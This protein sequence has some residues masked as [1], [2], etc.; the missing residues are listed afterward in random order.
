[1]DRTAYEFGPPVLENF[2]VQYMLQPL[3]GIHLNSDIDGEFQANGSKTFLQVFMAVALLILLIA[4]FNF[5][6]LST[7]R[8]SWRAKEV[9]VKKVL[10]IE[11]SH[12]VA[13]F[14]GESLLLTVISAVLAISIVALVLPYF[15]AFSG[16]LLTNSMFF[17]WDLAVV[18]L[19]ILILV[20]LS[21]G[22]FPAFFLSSFQPLKVLKG[23]TNMGDTKLASRLRKGLVV[24]QFAI[25]MGLV[26]SSIVIYNQLSYA[27]NMNLG[28]KKEQV[29]VVDFYNRDLRK[30]VPLYKTAVQSLN[31]V[32]GVAA[33]SDTPPREL[34]S[35][36]MEYKKGEQLRKELVPVIAVVHN[37]IDV[38]QIGIK[39]GRNFS[40]D[41]TTDEQSGILVNEA[42]VKFFD[43]QGPLNAE[44]V[45]SEDQPVRILGVMED[46]HFN[47]VHQRIKPVMLRIRP[48]WH[49]HLM[50][51]VSDG[52]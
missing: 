15:S 4:C 8:A 6:N 28:L 29:I 9:G 1:V 41:F 16:K 17:S 7:A 14:L 47:S 36:W 33:T 32:S 30:Q 23:N 49:D 38:L 12:L 35:W 2:K 27:K 52:D 13:Q 39:E 22:S 43:L 18:F 31:Q 37:S 40:Q 5:V 19:S 24:M 50:V 34:N 44:L 42:L 51:R 21:A 46:F 45:L 11:R 10:G 48:S 25:S 3:K 26:V 20:G